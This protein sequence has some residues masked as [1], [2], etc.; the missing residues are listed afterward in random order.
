MVLEL[1]MLEVEN[2]IA[3]IFSVDVTEIRI[4]NNLVI[5]KII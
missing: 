3:H 5:A 4:E 1:N 2:P